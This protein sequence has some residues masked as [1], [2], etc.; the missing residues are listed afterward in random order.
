[1][2]QKLQGYTM[3]EPVSLQAI[4]YYPNHLPALYES[5]SDNTQASTITKAGP[6]LVLALI[7]TIVVRELQSSI[8]HS[9]SSPTE[10]IEEVFEHIKAGDRYL[11]KAAL[12]K[13]I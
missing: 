3:S 8:Y 6:S 9:S 12:S 4:G 7:S 13:N 2:S 1:M 11:F 5:E 10:A